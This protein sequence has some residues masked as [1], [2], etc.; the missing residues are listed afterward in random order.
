MTEFYDYD[1]IFA[2]IFSSIIALEINDLNFPFTFDIFATVL[3]ASGVGAWKAC[4]PP[5]QRREK[6]GALKAPSVLRG[7]QM[8]GSSLHTKSRWHAHMPFLSYLRRLV[9]M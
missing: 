9:P 7:R 6:M 8:P 3:V 5:P 2:A 4:S 1:I